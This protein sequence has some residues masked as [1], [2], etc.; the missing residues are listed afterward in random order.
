MT[1]RVREKMEIMLVV[2]TTGLEHFTVK[3]GKW[4]VM[5]GRRITPRDWIEDRFKNA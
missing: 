1:A 2:W 5:R 3:G 4:K